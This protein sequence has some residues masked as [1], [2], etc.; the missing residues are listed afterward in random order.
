MMATASPRFKEREIW[1]RTVSGPRGV[2]YS[3]ATL[4]TSSIDARGSDA[5]VHLE[6]PRGHPRGAVVL[7]DPLRASLAEL[8]RERRVLPQGEDS[9]GQAGRVV[10]FHEDPA[11]GLLED[12]GKCS[13]PRLDY[14]HSVRHSLQQKDSLRFVVGAGDGQDVELL[15]E[16][17]FLQPVEYAPIAEL[18][19]Q[20]RVLHLAFDPAAVLP[21]LGSQVAGDLQ[22]GVGI[23][24]LAPQPDVGLGQD[25]QALLRCY[26]REVSDRETGAARPQSGIVA[27]EAH[28]KWHDVHLVAWDAEVTAH[29]L[30]VVF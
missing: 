21:V 30:R 9:L 24:G 20:A 4:E 8:L 1:E 5:G 17:D 14:R 3:L 10:R 22:R 16:I 19:I 2:G 13:A 6:R 27:L 18:V 29:E 7:S 23:L 15:Q 11:A 26:A 25:V 28:A 12:L